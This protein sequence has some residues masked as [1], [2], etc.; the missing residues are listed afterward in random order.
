MQYKLIDLQGMELK[1][2]MIFDSIAEVIEELADFHGVDYEGINDNNVPYKD[3]YQFL[4]T[5]K[6]EQERLDFLLDYGQWDIVPVKKLLVK[7]E[8]QE[9]EFYCTKCDSPMTDVGSAY[10]CDN[11]S[12]GY[13]IEK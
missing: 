8:K 7:H 4:D 5:L 12:C 13:N 1:E 6:T 10:V 11:E 9:D 2:D 3:I